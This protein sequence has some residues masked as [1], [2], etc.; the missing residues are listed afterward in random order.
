VKQRIV[1]LGPPASGK[2]TQAGLIHAKYGIETPSVGA[3][4][5]EQ[6]ET[7]TAVGLA[8]AKLTNQ[9]LLVPDEITVDVVRTWLDSHDGAFVF[10]GFPRTLGQAEALE[11]MLNKRDTP[12]QIALSLEVDN[13]TSH[14]RVSRRMVCSKCGSIVSIG[15]H[16][17][18]AES[19]CPRCE[20]AL[21]RR[22]DDTVE[23]LQR[24]W[25]EYHE[26]SAPLL[27]FYAE[28]GLLTNIA[29]HS[30]PEEVFAE[31][32]AALEGEPAYVHS[33]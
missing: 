22:G 26:K 30:A 7:G 32:T 4:L 1:L 8:A 12:L 21:Q 18:S 9:G 13:A 31:V 29:A 28:R 6:Q 25:I 14:D 16:V 2:G 11:R 24:R 23:T 33:H 3:I 5:R 19:V 17:A 15:L 20:S 10:D 27:S